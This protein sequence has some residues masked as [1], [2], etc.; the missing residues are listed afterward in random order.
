[1]K[2]F[3]VFKQMSRCVY[4][5]TPEGYIAFTWDCAW[6]DCLQQN[7]SDLKIMQIQINS[8]LLRLST[9]IYLHRLKS[10]QIYSD[11]LT[12]K[13]RFYQGFKPGFFHHVSLFC[14]TIFKS[15]HVY[16]LLF[17]AVH[18]FIVFKWRFPKG[19]SWY[20][21]NWFG[22]SVSRKDQIWEH[23]LNGALINI[24]RK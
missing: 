19:V 24:L 14:F 17:M 11:L 5:Y 12:A 20:D 23:L 2:E 10:T 3:E 4:V 1:M 22:G 8:N 7:V 9:Q 16:I 18:M 15:L 13:H 6:W 21:S